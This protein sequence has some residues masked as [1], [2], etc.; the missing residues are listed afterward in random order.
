MGH[1]TMSERQ[2]ARPP[3]PRRFL[4]GSIKMFLGFIL[5]VGL[6]L[7][8]WVSQSREQAAAVA[9]ITKFR[10]FGARYDGQEFTGYEAD[11]P[12][13]AR[14]KQWWP[15]EFLERWL[16]Y[17]LF[18]DVVEVTIGR[19][20]KPDAP[21]EDEL[22]AATIQLRRLKVLRVEFDVSDARAEQLT[23]LTA[24]E[25]LV[26]PQA[27]EGLTDRGMKSISAI[28]TLKSLHLNHSAVTPAGLAEL[29]KLD[30][31]ES[32]STA[33]MVFVQ[34][35]DGVSVRGPSNTD[36]SPALASL[37]KLHNLKV[38][39]LGLPYI[40]GAGL[41]H[42]GK[43]KSLKMLEIDSLSC[44]DDDLRHLATLTNLQVL[45]LSATTIDG[46]GFRHLGG[47]SQLA[48][49]VVKRAPMLSDPMILALVRLPALE[50]AMLDGSHLTADG[51]VAFRA[52]SKL[53]FLQV[54][55]AV[56]D[57]A[58]RLQQ[59]LPLCQVHNGLGGTGVETGYAVDL[60]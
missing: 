15:P 48:H 26:M 49:V 47:L 34:D 55:P 3:R 58:G 35:A 22:L 50:M 20:Y 30:R 52:A 1:S 12:A 39:Y 29:G 2:T 51:L 25:D 38:L 13:D 23:R 14:T 19:S 21:S 8:W 53:R 18:R 28:R 10:P 43:I 45:S 54:D 33:N 4:R 36:W 31:L 57:E 7:G 11:G 24:L 5:I 40:N 9:L 6:G 32:L 42:L 44:R 17:D 56:A 16:G 37:G 27:N 59:A 60:K 46:T 41:S